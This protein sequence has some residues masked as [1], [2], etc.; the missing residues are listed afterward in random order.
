MS[1][2]F[3]SAKPREGLQNPLDTRLYE[4]LSIYA[5]HNISN[6]GII[7]ICS[8][9]WKKN[10]WPGCSESYWCPG[11]ED[12]PLTDLLLFVFQRDSSSC[13][14]RS[15]ETSSENCRKSLDLRGPNF[16]QTLF[17]IQSLLTAQNGDN[18]PSEGWGQTEELGGGTWMRPGSE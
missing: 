16:K 7:G 14:P 17:F 8:P 12:N 15:S 18:V 1:V 11:S 3:T 5:A 6:G 13:L 4:L 10:D 9:G 2:L